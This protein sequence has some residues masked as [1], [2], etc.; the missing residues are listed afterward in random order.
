MVLGSNELDDVMDLVRVHHGFRSVRRESLA[1]IV[2]IA[3]VMMMVR[4]C[5]RE[6]G[7]AFMKLMTLRIWCGTYE[8]NERS[9]QLGKQI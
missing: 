6:S 9:Q 4:I 1:A 5:C 3:K 8:R 7:A 2:Q